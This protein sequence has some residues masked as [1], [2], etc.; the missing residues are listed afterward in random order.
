MS[1]TTPHLIVCKPRA[2]A[3]LGGVRQARP[4]RVQ[5][6][7]F[8]HTKIFKLNRLGSQHLLYEVDAPLREFLDPPLPWCSGYPL[9]TLPITLGILYTILTLLFPPIH[10]MIDHVLKHHQSDF[11]SSV[12]QW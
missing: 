4:L 7:S 2:L 5:I 6:L 8:R 12:V 1:I 9:S 10:T 11:Q 3:G